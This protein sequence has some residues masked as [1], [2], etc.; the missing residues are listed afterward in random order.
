MPTHAASVRAVP[1]NASAQPPE[2]PVPD[3][4]G[5]ASHAPCALHTLG[6]A[7]SPIVAHCVLQ[8]PASHAYGAHG[9][10]C[11]PGMTISFVE[12]HIAPAMH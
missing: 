10:G 3:D 9:F 1:S 11:A 12:S 7:Q 2:L 5:G 8:D 4:D 6:A